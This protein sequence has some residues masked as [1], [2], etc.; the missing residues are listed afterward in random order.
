[1][2]EHAA[3]SGCEVWQETQVKSASVSARRRDRDLRPGWPDPRA[4]EPLDF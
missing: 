2:L 1:M 4:E 3:E